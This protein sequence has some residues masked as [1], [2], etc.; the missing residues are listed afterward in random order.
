VLLQVA[1][2]DGETS[3]TFLDSTQ[4]AEHADA[5]RVATAQACRTRSITSMQMLVRVFDRT[6]VLF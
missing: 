2:V 1:I 5:V 6:R 4:A 3:D